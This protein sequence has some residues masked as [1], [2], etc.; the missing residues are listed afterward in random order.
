MGRMCP[1]MNWDLFSIYFVICLHLSPA[2]HVTLAQSVQILFL[3]CNLSAPPLWNQKLFV[4]FNVLIKHTRP[5]PL[6]TLAW[7]V[8]DGVGPEIC[9]CVKNTFSIDFVLL[10]GQ[11]HILRIIDGKM[12]NHGSWDA[13]YTIDTIQYQIRPQCHIISMTQF[14]GGN[15]QFYI[16]KPLTQTSSSSKTSSVHR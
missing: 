8:L 14:N 1:C 12:T 11:Q 6:S 13:E 16:V 15:T 2:S 7:L 3:R 10:S 4:V 9:V 5:C